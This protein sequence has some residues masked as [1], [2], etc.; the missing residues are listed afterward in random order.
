MF[1]FRRRLHTN[2]WADELWS[3]WEQL[4]TAPPKGF[5]FGWE[6]QNVNM[7]SGL[8]LETEKLARS[9]LSINN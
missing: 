1:G 8:L 7:K 4:V 9:S 5:H 6:D 3:K 2:A